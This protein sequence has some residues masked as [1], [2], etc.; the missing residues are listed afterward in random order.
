MNTMC[1][2]CELPSPHC[3][4]A[5]PHCTH[6]VAAVNRDCVSLTCTRS[7][8][9]R[10]ERAGLQQLMHTQGGRAGAEAQGQGLQTALH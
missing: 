4:L 3:T 9:I 2:R 6:R 7:K 8:S 5:V 1:I 10:L